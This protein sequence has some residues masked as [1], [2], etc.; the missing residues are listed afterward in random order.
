[1]PTPPKKPAP[2]RPDQEPCS[3]TLDAQCVLIDD[4]RGWS[5]GPG[6]ADDDVGGNR[7]EAATE[8]RCR[9]R[10]RE[11]GASS[12]RC[13]ARLGRRE[14]EATERRSRETITVVIGIQ[15]R[16][17][18][19]RREGCADDGLTRNFAQWLVI[20]LGVLPYEAFHLYLKCCREPEEGEVAVSSPAHYH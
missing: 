10:R 17:E 1:M 6:R 7:A 2:E 15:V 11:D 16:R 12:R 14:E 8:R 20:C 9:R 19:D 18:C 5:G 13:F 3:F 4:G